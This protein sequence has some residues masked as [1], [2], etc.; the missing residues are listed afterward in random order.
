M[1]LVFLEWYTYNLRLY[2]SNL[3]KHGMFY[4]QDT[5]MTKVHL[6]ITL[7]CLHYFAFNTLHHNMNIICHLSTSGFCILR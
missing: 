1:N 3:K 2:L 7:Y 4:Q 5:E 6:N